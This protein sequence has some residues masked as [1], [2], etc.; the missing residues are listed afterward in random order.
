MENSNLIT[1]C[2][3]DCFGV[4]YDPFLMGW[5]KDHSTKHDFVD[6]KLHE[7]LK[8]FDL[9]KLSEEDVLDHFSKYKGIT[10]NKTDLRDHIDTYLRLDTKLVDM[11]KQLKDGGYKTVL[12]SN[13]NHTFFDRKIYPTFPQFKDIFDEII[14]SS[15][16]GMVKPEPDIFLYTLEKTNTKP[17]EALFIDDSKSNVEAA[18]K[19]GING[20]LYTNSDDFISFLRLNKN[21][22]INL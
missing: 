17:E 3:F 12:L 8:Q 20:Y 19:L 22:D 18:M 16:V 21:I 7:V 11:I 10:L 15:Q 6:E 13:A 14:I 2:I 9:G 5:Y 1:T 4:I